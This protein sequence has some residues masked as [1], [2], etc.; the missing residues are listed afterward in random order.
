MQS[1]TYTA[2]SG[3]LFITDYGADDV[4]EITQVGRPSVVAGRSSTKGGCPTPGLVARSQRQ[5]SVVSE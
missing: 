3:E 1:K 4:E 5:A 2:H